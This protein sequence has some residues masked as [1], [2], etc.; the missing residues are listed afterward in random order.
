M[1]GTIRKH[2]SWLW[3]IIAGLT[4]VS[5]VGFMSSGPARGGRGGGGSYG[6]IYGKEVTLVTYAQAQREFRL[7][8]WLHNGDWPEKNTNIKRTDIDRETYVRLLLVAKANKLGIHVSDDAVVASANELLRSLGRNGQAVPMDQFVSQVL[9]REGL[10]AADFQHF[11]R[12]DLAIQQLVQTLGLVGALTPPQEAA[13]LYDREHQEISAQAVFFSASNFLAQ[14]AVTPAA[15]AQFYTNYLAAYREPDRVQVSYVAY[16]VSNYLAA[17]EQK[18]GLTNLNTQVETF[19]REHGLESVPDAKTPVEA[20]AKIRTYFLNQAA[21]ADA[22]KAAGDFANELFAQEPVKPENLAALAR[23]K[24][25]AVHTTAPFAAAYGPEEFNA[26]TAFTKAA[27]RLSAEEPF[28]GPL[29]GTDTIYVL[30]LAG[31]LPSAIPPLAQI[32]ARVTQDFQE[33]EAVALAQHAGTNFYF[34]ASVQLAVGKKFTQAVAAAGQLPVLLAPFSLSSREIPEAGEIDPRLLKQAAFTTA[35]GKISNF[36]PTPEGGF[37][38]YVKAV[39][40]VDEAK[41]KTEL[42]QFLAQ[43]RR[44]RQNEAFNLWLQAEAGRELRNTPVFAELT[45]AKTPAH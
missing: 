8:Y 40:P 5:F 14:V 17:A 28:A 38:L 13:A 36:F 24:G 34:S 25:L 41:K 26:P 19:F 44:G 11:L 35:P 10:S 7:Y 21:L 37:V 12:D 29:A 2:S 1:F 18:I 32:R 16:E 33:R 4:I 30:A 22:K 45:G 31:Q 20:K 43:V 27:F 6:T 15:V 39:L 23:K 42:P 9:A 3:W